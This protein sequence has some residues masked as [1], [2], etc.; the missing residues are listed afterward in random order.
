MISLLF[1]PD[2]VAIHFGRG[3]WPDSWATKETN[4]LLMLFLHVIVF[5]PL[6]G[7]SVLI[8][9]V[10]PKFLSLPYKKFWLRDENRE[11]AKQ[12][13]AGYM[14]KF[15]AILF[16]FLLGVSLLTI[17]ANRTAPVRLNEGLFLVLLAGFILYTIVWMIRLVEG[18]RPSGES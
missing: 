18:L 17:Q 5:L 9:R 1:L 6:Y 8:D 2:T 4:T 11:R 13:M 3:G 15:G 16:L 7:V 14:N 10:P 12:L